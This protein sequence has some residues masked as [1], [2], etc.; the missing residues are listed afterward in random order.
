MPK[1]KGGSTN[2]GGWSEENMKKAIEDVLRGSTYF[3]AGSNQSYKQGH[4]I[5]LK[6]KLRHLDFLGSALTDIP[7]EYRSHQSTI[8]APS[9]AVVP[10]NEPEP[11]T[12]AL[13][14]TSTTFQEAVPSTSVD[15]KK[16][17]D[18]LEILSPLPDALNKRRT[19]KS[20]LIKK[21]QDPK[22]LAKVKK[23][24]ETKVKAKRV[25][26]EPHSQNR[27]TECIICGETF[28]ENWI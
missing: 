28:D 12:S 16:V 13:P 8:Q 10:E 15:V 25:A 17:N 1:F 7:A 27:D 24:M 21:A 22:H 4:Q 23:N 2:R 5:T 20:E 26:P 6:P 14:V 19:H 3:S 18:A 9:P 11:S